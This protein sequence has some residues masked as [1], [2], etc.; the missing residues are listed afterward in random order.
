MAYRANRYIK[1]SARP[2]VEDQPAFSN[3]LIEHGIK[4][5]FG[6]SQGQHYLIKTFG[7]L[8]E[9]ARN[10]GCPLASILLKKMEERISSL[11]FFD[12]KDTIKERKISSIK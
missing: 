1:K 4:A 12:E 2:D 11:A 6:A 7:N 5:D 8:S 9:L 3:E 10:E